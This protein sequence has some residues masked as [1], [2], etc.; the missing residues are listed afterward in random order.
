MKS[1]DM[2]KD[3]KNRVLFVLPSLRH[4]V[5]LFV[6]F[7]HMLLPELQAVPRAWHQN[8]E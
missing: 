6:Y 5:D 8:E 3:L 7:V 2:V 1:V 4:E